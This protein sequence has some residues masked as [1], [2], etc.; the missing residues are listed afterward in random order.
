MGD[1]P[2]IGDGK[3]RLALCL[4]NDCESLGK[5]LFL[6]RSGLKQDEDFV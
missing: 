3:G 2:W 6:C 5:E 4:I 1:L